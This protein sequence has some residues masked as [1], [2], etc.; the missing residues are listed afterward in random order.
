MLGCDNFLFSLVLSVLSIDIFKYARLFHCRIF[1]R[2]RNFNECRILTEDSS[3][4]FIS[5]C[6]SDAQ[7]TYPYQ[8]YA[9]SLSPWACTAKICGKFFTACYCTTNNFFNMIETIKIDIISLLCDKLSFIACR[10]S[11]FLQ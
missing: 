7:N 10:D 1:F 9:K 3:D 6:H 8:N 2:R 5:M 11:K 4:I